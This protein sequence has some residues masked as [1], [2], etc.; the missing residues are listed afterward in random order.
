MDQYTIDCLK[1]NGPLDHSDRHALS[2]KLAHSDLAIS[3]TAKGQLAIANGNLQEG[4]KCFDEA[5]R[6][7][8]N[9]ANMYFEQGLALFEYCEKYKMTKTLLMA[10]KKFKRATMLVPHYFEA[11][12]IWTKTL[13]KLGMTCKEHHYFQEAQKKALCAIT[14]S[15]Q[16]APDILADLHWKLGAIF[17]HLALHSGEALDLHQAINAFYQ[18]QSVHQHL[19]IEYWKDYATACYLFAEQI[20][21]AHFHLKAIACIKNA[22]ALSPNA[23]DCWHLLA[24]IFQSLYFQTHDEDH[25]IKAEDAYAQAATLVSDSSILPSHVHLDFSIKSNTEFDGTLNESCSARTHSST[26]K[27][28]N[29]CQIQEPNPA[30]IWFDWAEFLCLSSRRICNIKRLH[31]CVEKCQRAILCNPNTAHLIEI[32]AIWIEALALLGSETERLDLLFEA[33]NRITEVIE[34]AEHHPAIWYAFGA[35]LKAFGDY[36][37]DFDYYTQAIEKFQAGLSIDRTCHAHWRAIAHIYT[38]L[39]ELGGEKEDCERSIRF[40]QKAIDLQPCTFYIIDYAIALSKLGE[41]THEQQWLEAASL[42]FE[43]ALAL[44]KNALYLH[45]NWLLHYAC[46]LDALGDFQEEDA[47]YLRAIEIFSHVLM[48]DPDCY[49]AHHRLALSLSH[50][51]EVSNEIEHFHRAIRH[52]RIAAKHDPENDSI[53]LDY[54]TILINI[55]HRNC[56]ASQ[57]DQLYKDAEQELWNAIRLGNAQGYYLLACLYSLM[58]QCEKSMSCL[59]RATHFDILPSIDE[60]LQDEW[61][62][63]LRA[64]GEF[65]AFLSHLEQRGN[66]QDEY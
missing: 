46:C 37:N 62:D 25:F 57:A 32:Q 51:G 65:I 36:F 23:Y 63:N 17:V 50:L 59:Y 18:A 45:P 55:A 47:Y 2:V 28:K 26:G 3:I 10:S 43:R 34:T 30:C 19:P 49:T 31:S 29:A 40:F 54:A 60:M 38:L 58:D 8:P 15:P 61:L 7:D 4:L 5:L 27:D 24:R 52:L 22:L 13:F 21:D 41:M 16:Q 42:E 64:T 56:I 9:N 53:V 44:Q 12:H 66:L 48:I 14:L 1:H 11:W 20:N 39:A 35:V 6:L 33:Q